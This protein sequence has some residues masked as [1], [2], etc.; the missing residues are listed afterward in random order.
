MG[1][2]GARPKAAGRAWEQSWESTC[3]TACHTLGIWTADLR[4]SPGPENP[5]G[6]PSRLKA[7]LPS[8]PKSQVSCR[9][10]RDPHRGWKSPHV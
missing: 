5:G 2:A 7:D 10:G 3:P 9:A 8:N 4:A 6:T 1:G